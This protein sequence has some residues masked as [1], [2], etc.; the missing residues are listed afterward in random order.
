MYE[1]INLITLNE[2]SV[3]AEVQRMTDNRMIKS[4]S[5]S[6]YWGDKLL[7]KTAKMTNAMDYAYVGVLLWNPKFMPW[8]TAEI[9]ERII[10]TFRSADFIMGIKL[11][12]GRILTD[13][14]TYPYLDKETREY[15]N[16]QLKCQLLGYEHNKVAM[17]GTLRLTTEILSGDH[18]V[19]D[20]RTYGPMETPALP[21]LDALLAVAYKALPGEGMVIESDIPD[22]RLQRDVIKAA[23][24]CMSNIGGMAYVHG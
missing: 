5:V 8:M 19:S 1:R 15:V 16:I 13:G 20:T 6:V 9:R 10:N 7:A 18:V 12:P 2:L 3:Y 14:I 24:T 11:N 17:T 23:D 21:D 4:T 22:D